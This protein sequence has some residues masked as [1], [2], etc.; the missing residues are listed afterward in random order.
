MNCMKK[1]LNLFNILLLTMFLC[2]GCEKKGFLDSI[3]EMY[4]DGIETVD[5]AKSIDD[6]QKC[7]NDINKKVEEFLQNHLNEIAALDSTATKIEAAKMTFTKACCIKAFSFEGFIKDTNGVVIGVNDAGKVLPLESIEGDDGLVSDAE[8]DNY[9]DK[10]PLGF[11]DYS[12][13]YMNGNIE[14]LTVRTSNG[15]YLYNEEDA[16]QYYDQYVS[17]F[18]FAN[19]IVRRIWYSDASED[20]KKYVKD[21]LYRIVSNLPI[22]INLYPRDVVDRVNNVYYNYMDKAKNLHLLRRNNGN[23]IYDYY[24]PTKLYISRDPD[25]GGKLVITDL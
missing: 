23:S 11:I 13:I 15:V 17:H 21:N 16:E 12:Y 7:Y 3:V 25:H 24:G 19:M 8:F 6:V 22:D 18:F 10:N 1:H 20:T 2:I 9:D 5:K 4:D 14:Y